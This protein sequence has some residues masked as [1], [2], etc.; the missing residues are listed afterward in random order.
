M[1]KEGGRTKKEGKKKEGRSMETERNT[2]EKLKT[3]NMKKVKYRVASKK[4]LS[5]SNCH[6]YKL[7]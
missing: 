1:G 2:K 6:V 7:Y 4:T 3:R 5:N